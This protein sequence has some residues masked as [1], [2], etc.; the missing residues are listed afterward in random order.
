MPMQGHNKYTLFATAHGNAGM[1]YKARSSALRAS[2]DSKG[3]AKHS[4][5]G[6]LHDMVSQGLLKIAKAHS[7]EFERGRQAHVMAKSMIDKGQGK[8]AVK[9]DLNEAFDTLV[10]ALVER[11]PTDFA[12]TM[13][14]LI[15]ARATEMV[16]ARK[17]EVAKQTF[18]VEEDFVDE[19]KTFRHD[20]EGEEKREKFQKRRKERHKR[21]VEVEEEVQPLDEISAERAKA[22]IG[23]AEGDFQKT[24]NKITKGNADKS[25]IKRSKKRFQGIER[26]S[27]KVN[28]ETG[29]LTIDF[30]GELTEEQIQD[31]EELFGKGKIEGIMKHHGKMRD[32]HGDAASSFEDD[33][34]HDSYEHHY[35]KAMDHEG[36]LER[37]EALK[38]VRD[39]AKAAKRHKEAKDDAKMLNPKNGRFAGKT[40]R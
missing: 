35:E 20:E 10:N 7:K 4:R 8:M 3:A 25:D 19:G 38:R 14:E 5:I 21:E 30:D 18:N 28:E 16:A 1:Q 9:E 40:H 26:A 29:V 27:F 37:G 34:D 13:A 17:I 2:G 33:G 39:N 32:K 11:K 15:Q 6:K 31:L 22:Y 36:K 24:Q 12:E 23:K